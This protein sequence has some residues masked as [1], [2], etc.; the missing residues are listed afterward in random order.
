MDWLNKLLG[1]AGIEIPA[2]P[3]E[4]LLNAILEQLVKPQDPQVTITQS[5]GYLDYFLYFAL[6]LFICETAFRLVRAMGDS[7]FN[8]EM[9]ELLISTAWLFGF[10]GLAPGF[11]A[12]M[13]IF[14]NLIGQGLLTL[15]MGDSSW[16]TLMSKLGELSGSVA[17]DFFL[18]I[19]QIGSLI[20]TA[21]GLAIMLAS[22]AASLIILIVGMM[23]RWLGDFGTR[24]FRTSIAITIYSVVINMVLMIVIGGLNAIGRGIFPGA[25]GQLWR[26]MINT[27]ALVLASWIIWKIIGKIG[28]HVRAITSSAAGGIRNMRSRFRGG[29]TSVDPDGAIKQRRS[30]E[31][32]HD[33][34]SQSISGRSGHDGSSQQHEKRGAQTTHPAPKQD[35]S[36]PT[37]SSSSGESHVAPSAPPRQRTRSSTA[38]RS[39][40]S[41]GN[42]SYAS[43]PASQPREGYAPQGTT[44]P[45]R[46]RKPEEL[47]AHHRREADVVRER[48]APTPRPVPERS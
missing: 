1:L 12:S 24:S 27:G 13:R 19:I 2:S 43:P 32:V 18:S 25:G 7:N 3:R 41:S 23:L 15:F 37:P 35:G 36:G 20:V 45:P 30:A 34:H 39:V 29:S 47:N 38:S 46:Q 42:A 21:I 31:Q 17:I 44:P 4:S 14:A 40:N 10:V 11:L 28:A 22:F 9:R 5:Y 6:A 8:A 26:G 33:R 16:A 48:N